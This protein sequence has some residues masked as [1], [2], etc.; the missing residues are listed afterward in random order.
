MLLSRSRHEAGPSCGSKVLNVMLGREEDDEG[1][2]N[3][4]YNRRFWIIARTWDRK[5]E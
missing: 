5:K 1:N 2:S 3:E 4:N